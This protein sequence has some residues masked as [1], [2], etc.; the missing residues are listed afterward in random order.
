MRLAV[1]LFRAVDRADK[2]RGMRP[3]RLRQIFDDAGNA[4]VALDQHDV[5]GLDDAPQMF[6][7]AWRERLVAGYFL[8][9]V[10]RDQL[11]DGIKHYTHNT[12][13]PGAFLTAFFPL[14][15][16]VE[17]RCNLVHASGGSIMIDSP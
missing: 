3:G 9:E 8:L 6:G 10:P 14:L 17:S 12:H 15:S 4:V 11:A 7:V 13:P 16:M 5:A 2:K 1:G